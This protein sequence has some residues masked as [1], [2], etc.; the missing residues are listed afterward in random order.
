MVSA[1]RCDR[2]LFQ[3]AGRNASVSNAADARDMVIIAE[4]AL[5]SSRKAGGT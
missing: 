2:C 5:Q 4:T 3:Y 1:D